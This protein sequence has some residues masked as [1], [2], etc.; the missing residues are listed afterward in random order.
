MVFVNFISGLILKKNLKN[1]QF[2]INVLP[3]I[4]SFLMCNKV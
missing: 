3:S 1:I 2:Y 4:F